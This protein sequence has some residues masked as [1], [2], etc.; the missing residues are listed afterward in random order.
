MA[1]LYLSV[2]PFSQQLRQPRALSAALVQR[3]RPRRQGL[4]QDR[5]A[6]HRARAARGDL[7]PGRGGALGRRAVPLQGRLQEGKDDHVGGGSSSHR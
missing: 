1:L 3:L 6:G 2:S 7:P 4:L 5:P